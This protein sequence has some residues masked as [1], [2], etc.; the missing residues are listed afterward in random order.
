M[1]EA[2]I[3]LSEKDIEIRMDGCC[4]RT[5]IYRNLTSLVS[6]GIIQR[7][8]SGD[9]QKYKLLNDRV[10]KKKKQDHVHFQ[11]NSCNKLICLEDLMVKDY[12]LPEGF[13]R[14]ENQFLIVGLCKDCNHES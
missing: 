11:C 10:S 9:S 4:N 13:T 12:V 14:L 2:E 6:K 5:T 3:P 7:I 1:K 8:I